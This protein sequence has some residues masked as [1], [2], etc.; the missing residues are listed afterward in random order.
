MVRSWLQIRLYR[1]SQQWSFIQAEPDCIL[2][3]HGGATLPPILKSTLWPIPFLAVCCSLGF[4][5]SRR[6][7]FWS[8]MLVYSIRSS[9]QGSSQSK[10]NLQCMHNT[11]NKLK[12]FT[13]KQHNHIICNPYPD[14]VNCARHVL[15]VF[16]FLPVQGPGENT[17]C[18]WIISL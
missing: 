8:Q 16:F 11:V 7:Q 10:D 18:T 15:V 12:N 3:Y 4:C 1:L 13:L 9:T 17:Y 14:S 5:S 2:I 6:Q